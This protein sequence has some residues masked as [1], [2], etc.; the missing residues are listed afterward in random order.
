VKIDECHAF[1][2]KALIM[3]RK[4]QKILEFGFGAGEATRAILEGLAF[5]RVPFEYTLVDNWLDFDG[6]RS[7]RSFSPTFRAVRFVT[8]DESVYVSS[9][10]DSYDFIFSD[11]DHFGAERWFPDVYDR[12]LKPGGTLVYHDVKNP[13]FPNLHEIYDG[14]RRQNLD[15]LLLDRSVRE[16]EQCERGMLVIFKPTAAD[17]LGRNIGVSAA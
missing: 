15:H 2:A 14:V 12:L 10:Q 16:D 8:Q 17:S 9:C 4:P 11:A 6:R 7:Q 5:N 1:F 3:T 13:M